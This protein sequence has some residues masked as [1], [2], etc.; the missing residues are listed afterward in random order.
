MAVAAGRFWRIESS[1]QTNAEL[2]AATCVLRTQNGPPHCSAAEVGA[3]GEHA[4][5]SPDDGRHRE[6]AR[7]H[8]R[9]AVET[10]PAHPQ[11]SCAE[12]REREIR[13]RGLP[14]VERKIH[15]RAEVEGNG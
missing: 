9:A 3:R 6:V 11:K 7:V 14:L 5:A 4:R 15:A 13:R 2:H 1:S 10:E 8:G 12:P